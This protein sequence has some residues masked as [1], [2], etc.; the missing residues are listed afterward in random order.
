MQ[1][2]LCV[3]T[4]SCAR[5]IR[6]EMKKFSPPAVIDVFIPRHRDYF[7]LSEDPFKH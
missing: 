6:E 7:R 3:Q 2:L 1:I 5:V 4:G